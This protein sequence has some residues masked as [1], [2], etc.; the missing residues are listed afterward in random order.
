M[1]RTV[2]RGF[3]VCELAVTFI[4]L[5]T[6]AAAPAHAV[7]CD[8]AAIRAQNNSTGLPDCRVYELVTNPFKEGFA[9]NSVQYSDGDAVTYRSSG[10]FAGSQDGGLFNQYV[11]TR[12]ATGWQTTAPGPPLA[13]SSL[14]RQAFALGAVAAA[15]DMARDLR[16]SVWLMRRADEST[17]IQDFY[18]R[19]VDGSFTRIGPGPNPALLPEG[20]SGT[21]L[22]GLYPVVQGSSADLSHVIFNLPVGA[23]YPGDSAGPGTSYSL[24]EYVGTGNDRPRLVGVDNS[25]QQVSQGDTCAGSATS[26]YHAISTDGRVIFFSPGCGGT[27]WARINGATSVD[28]AAS[29]CARAP[30][31]PAGSCGGAVGATFQGAA[32]DGSRAF[33]TTAQQLVDGDIDQTTDLYACDIPSGTPAPIGVANPC[34]ALNDVSGAAADANVQG[35]VRIS[36]DGSRV[37]FVAQGVLAANVGANHAT[38]VPGDNNL[39]VWEKDAAH[40]AGL[41]TFVAKLDP[42]DTSLWGGEGSSGASRAAQATDDGRYLVLSTLSP[43]VDSGP[44]ADTDAAADVYRYDADS[45]SLERLSIDGQGGG[46]N[47]PGS[48]VTLSPVSYQLS[49]ATLRPRTFMSADA[50][51]VVFLTSEAL[52][53]DDANGT[54]DVYAW[55]DGHVSLISSGRPAAPV[56]TGGVAW[57]TASGADIYFN[58]T[59]RLTPADGDTNAD[60]Y[61]ARIDGG[62]DFSRPGPCVGDGCQRPTSSPGLAAPGSG[63]AGGS[64]GVLDVPPTF[65][66]HAVSS[67]QRKRLSAT[68]KVTLT[69]T[70]NTAGTL[71]ATATA[72]IGRM[73]AGVA[74]ARRTLLAPGTASLAL[75]L[76]KRARTQLATSGKLAVKVVVSS[77][78]V[79]LTRSVTLKLT[80]VKAKGR[81][82]AMEKHKAMKRALGERAAAAIKGGRS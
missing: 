11:A 22:T 70:A 25:G 33:F 13:A 27:V 68:G 43:L 10:T 72:T 41:T 65:S 12:S 71:T 46:G 19:G 64:G 17:D 77:S 37:Y 28:L 42:N 23:R 76:S 15:E 63:T 73:S 62:F 6:F 18:L 59:E 2:A 53:P 14:V 80:H 1:P 55:R 47:E 26:L 7:A 29:Q 3:G 56:P 61:D 34:P 60:I 24:Y 78:K 38:A 81:A 69:A 54:Q 31:D 49:N 44:T 52:S 32:A 9:P 5:L 57:I 66:L 51:T 79:A 36:D 21:G 45:R 67:A 40:P 50:G 48:D 20:S 30:S 4:L 75:K 35:V 8:H 39:Y 82:T 16:S 58:S 74:S